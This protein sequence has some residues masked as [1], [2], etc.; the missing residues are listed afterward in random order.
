MAARA[1]HVGEDGITWTCGICDSENPF[2]LRT[3]SVCGAPLAA[4]LREPDAER[5]ERDPG[6]T[7]IISLLLPGAGHAYLGLWEQGIARA[8]TSVW[9]MFVLMATALEQSFFSATPMVF[10]VASFGLWAIASHDAYREAQHQ[11]GAVLLKGRSF[12]YVV[13]GLI[14]LSIVMI[15]VTAL[16]LRGA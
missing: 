1:F 13:L 11:P 5:V 7:A 10:A 3:C 8:V 9:V 6:K 12:F 16:S 14:A 2:E 15:F 4:T